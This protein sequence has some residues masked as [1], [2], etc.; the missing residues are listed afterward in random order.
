MTISPKAEQFR[1]LHLAQILREFDPK[2]GPF[3]LFLSNYFRHT[4]ALGSKDRADVGR[5]IYQIIRW[6]GLLLSQV[7]KEHE[8]DWCWQ[9]VINYLK[10]FDP[11][12]FLEDESLPAWQRVS[13]PE[14]LYSL[15]EKAYGK[16]KAVEIALSCNQEAPTTLRVNPLKCNRD[17]L[18][19]LL[20]KEGIEAKPT[21]LSPYGLHLQQ[22][23]QLFQLQAFRDG[24]FEMQDE[25]SQLIADLMKIKPGDEVLDYCAGSGGK[26]LAFAHKL[27]GKGQVYL[28]DIRKEALES[29]RQRLRRA[30]IQ[31][32][33]TMTFEDKRKKRILAGRMDWIFVDAPC[34]GTGTLRRNPDMKL[35]F[36]QEFLDGCIKLQQE[37]M[38]EALRFLKPSGHVVY[39]TCSILPEENE[40]QVARFC[41]EYNLEIVGVP[42]KSLPKT[43]G[44]DGFFAVCLKKAAPL[45]S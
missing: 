28:H 6:Q 30:G 38:R 13:F 37:V 16:E 20:Q 15:I 22:R 44:M 23:A 18:I 45:S 4:P 39:A 42:F 3:D 14:L 25:G 29:A 27:A 24:F 36:N 2:K 9:D 34:T 19:E 31:N 26:T 5:R 12:K 33:Q 7:K 11:K 10:D 43:G 32:S 41:S 40:E 8:G 35:R 21:E 1:D 17:Q